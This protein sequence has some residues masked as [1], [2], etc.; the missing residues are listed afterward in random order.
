MTQKLPKLF[1]E[2]PLGAALFAFAASVRTTLLAWTAWPPG[3]PALDVNNYLELG[4][5]LF[6]DG[7][8]GSHVSRDYPPL[9][10]MF[11]APF[12]SI[13]DA[14]AR[15]AAIL[16]AHGVVLALGCL[17][18]FPMLRSALGARRAWVALALVQFLAGT[19]YHAMATRSEVLFIALLCF[20]TA[21]IWSAFERATAGR[22]LLVGLTCGLAISCRRLGLALPVAAA[23]VVVVDAWSGSEPRLALRKVGVRGVLIGLGL[24]IGLLP[25][26][27]A[28][29]IH[30]SVIEAY[31]SGVVGSH[32]SPVTR[33]WE[34][35]RNILVG[36]SS[37][38]RQPLF[39]IIVYFGA[40]LILAALLLG[41]GHLRRV[42]RPLV[43]TSGFSL[44]VFLGLAAMSALHILRYAYG[45]PTK[46]DFH[47]YPRYL[48]PVETPI[49]LVAV[50]LAAAAFATWTAAELET[51]RRALIPW[52]LPVAL[53]FAVAGPAWRF[54]GGRL[55]PRGI[56]EGIEY[57]F[58]Y[59]MFFPGFGLLMLI[60]LMAWWSLGK[61]GTVWTI[62][63]AVVLSWSMSLHIVLRPGRFDAEPA[64]SLP[65]FSVPA[66]ADAPTAPVAVPVHRGS[67]WQKG[68]SPAAVRRG[69]YAPAWRTNNPIYWPPYR[70][71]SAWLVENPDGFVLTRSFEQ[72]PG[73]LL[74]LEL[75]G[76]TDDWLAWAP[77]G[78][79]ERR[80]FV[81]LRTVDEPA[82]PDSP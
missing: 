53:A 15:L 67:K 50:A 34:S 3:S 26:L 37:S 28:S 80:G 36:L 75:V 44:L 21:A 8:Y 59:K 54:P 35:T 18:L 52:M 47:L 33:M 12:F 62:V 51:R 27:V 68:L 78:R 45:N 58:L 56:F 11:I 81:D 14:Q 7:T 77:R 82:P 48:D 20:A 69:L 10:P 74:R 76:L 30:G 32:L 29:I 61:Y 4:L 22:W 79:P 25:E 9:Y 43:A 5:N 19:T 1:R 6:R 49:I 2:D 46:Q 63:A 24:G 17:S 66:L 71:L 57:F 72:A 40:P 73:H 55:P 70:E 60:V 41:R 38:F 31:H 65:I 13:D 42:P 39:G 64:P 16:G 23:I